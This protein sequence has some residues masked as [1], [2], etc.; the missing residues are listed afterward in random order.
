M[1]RKLGI[2]RWATVCN[3]LVVEMMF[4]AW[5]CC[6]GVQRRLANFAHASSQ[7]KQLT[8]WFL[9]LEERVACPV[10]QAPQ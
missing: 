2:Q 8:R 7:C 3:V 1:M 6:L 5:A 9:L 4:L 10:V